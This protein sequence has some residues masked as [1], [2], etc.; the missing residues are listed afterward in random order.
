[1]N[2]LTLA[3]AIASDRLEEFA[4]QAE[5]DGV[6][7]VDRTMFD[8]LIGRVTEPQPEDQ[9]SRSHGGGLKRGK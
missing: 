5:A 2:K 9:T 7:P 8:A 1:M 4:A 3:K 6:G